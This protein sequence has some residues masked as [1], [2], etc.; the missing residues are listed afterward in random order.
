MCNWNIRQSMWWR[1]SDI[2][3]SVVKVK[4]ACNIQFYFLPDF[5]LWQGIQIYQWLVLRK[6][7]RLGSCSLQTIQKE[8]CWFLVSSIFQVLFCSTCHTNL[9]IFLIGR[10][11]ALLD[12]LTSFWQ[13][14]APV[15]SEFV[16][17]ISICTAFFY[18]KNIGLF[19]LV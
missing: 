13:R 18:I 16:K 5:E 4:W 19:P 10:N 1:Q 3:Q 7:T 11:F 12:F 17:K 15:I 6:S 2:I 14:K 8:T 9:L